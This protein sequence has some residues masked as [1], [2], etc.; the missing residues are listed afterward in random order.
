MRYIINEFTIYICLL[1]GTVAKSRESVFKIAKKKIEV[2]TTKT[3]NFCY[4]SS[5]EFVKRVL[6][7]K[8]FSDWSINKKMI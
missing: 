1:S 4:Q 5:E 6:S 2:A 3:P 7:L 8:L